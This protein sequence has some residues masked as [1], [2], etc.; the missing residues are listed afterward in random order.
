M[1]LIDFDDKTYYR[2]FQKTGDIKKDRK[3]LEKTMKELNIKKGI[4]PDLDEKDISV[5][6]KC[7]ECGKIFHFDHVD[8][9]TYHAH[10]HKQAIYSCEDIKMYCLLE[11]GNCDEC[12][13]KIMLEKFDMLLDLGISLTNF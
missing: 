6:I 2:F 5:E 7:C 3:Y 11:V 12:S 10:K 9:V 4:T 13:K 1:A 8:M